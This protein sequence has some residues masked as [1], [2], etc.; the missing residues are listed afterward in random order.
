MMRRTFPQRPWWFRDMMPLSRLPSRRS[1]S[2][3]CSTWCAS[4]S[5][6][7]FCTRSLV[8][9]MRFR[10]RFRPPAF[11][12]SAS[13]SSSDITWASSWIFASG[14]NFSRPCGP[15]G[16]PSRVSVASVRMRVMSCRRRPR[17]GRPY[18]P[19]MR[20]MR[21]KPKASPPVPSP[22]WRSPRVMAPRLR[23]RRVTAET[24]RASPARSV[25]THVKLGGVTWLERCTR[26]SCCTALSAAQG[27]S[28]QIIRRGSGLDPARCSRRSLC[29][30]MPA[31]A[32]SVM[33]ANCF[34][35]FWKAR[36]SATFTESA[37]FPVGP[38]RGSRRTSPV[39]RSRQDL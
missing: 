38:V 37:S 35:P 4:S 32:A 25:T 29:S 30:E 36:C 16:Q 19:L 34:C 17:A 26:P 7:P 27:S 24:K 14:K 1:A 23:R 6:T 8:P 10:K 22:A 28:R 20:S 5:K 15:P 33:M 9:R 13:F 3:S 2:S 21:P 12:L 18:G 31:E 11:W 39:R